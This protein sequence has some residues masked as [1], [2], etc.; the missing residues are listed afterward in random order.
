MT[1]IEL[2]RPIPYPWWHDEVIFP[3]AAPIQDEDFWLPPLPQDSGFSNPQAL[4]QWKWDQQEAAGNLFGQADEDFP[5]ASLGPPWPNVGVPNPQAIAQW[6]WDEQEPAGSLFGQPDEDFWSPLLGP[7]P[8]RYLPDRVVIEV[9]RYDEQEPA[10]TLSGTPEE[11]DWLPAIPSL[12]PI[13]RPIT[14]DEVFA[15]PTISVDE[16]PWFAPPPQVS[17]RWPN[18]WTFDEQEPAGSLFG[19]PEEGEWFAPVPPPPPIVR[20]F[21][22]EDEIPRPPAPTLGV[23]EEPWFPPPPTAPIR[24]PHPWSFDEQ[25]PADALFGVAEET[26][27]F[28]PPPQAPLHWPWPWRFDEQEP[29]GV[30]FGVPEESEWFAPV[31]RVIVPP[32]AVIADEDF[33]PAPTLVAEEDVSLPTVPVPL[34]L[35]LRPWEADAQQ[36]VPPPAVLGVDE[37]PWLPPIPVPPLPL[38][39]LW[40]GDE[41]VVAEVPPAPG[42]VGYP[43]PINARDQEGMSQRD[44]GGVP[45]QDTGALPSRDAEGIVGRKVERMNRRL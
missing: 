34:Q 20:P 23:D 42:L 33:A 43:T 32:L 2:L 41:E 39:H 10:G 7:Q 28:A 16:E 8:A 14:D 9:W 17:I 21:A 15:F 1:R 44:Q 4:P 12:P 36:F 19:V 6:R 29:A 35:G 24:W 45:A 27:W 26:E 3:P 18:P 37:E 11:Q 31:P 13:V 40:F 38:P 30:L 22:A 5:P 25:E